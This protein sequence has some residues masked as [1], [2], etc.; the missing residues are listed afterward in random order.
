[1]QLSLSSPLCIGKTFASFS[2]F[3]KVPVEKLKLMINVRGMLIS[4]LH[5]FRIFVGRLF[6]PFALLFFRELILSSTSFGLVGFRKNISGEGFPKYCLKSFLDCFILLSDFWG[7]ST[8]NLLFPPSL[9][10]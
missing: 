3:G 9:F 2:L 5:S 8:K 4:F 7:I 10:Y 1:M 6:G